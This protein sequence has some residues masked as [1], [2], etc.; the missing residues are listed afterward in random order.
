MSNTRKQ[1]TIYTNGAAEP[2]PGPGGYVVRKSWSTAGSSC[3]D[4][5][6]RSM[7]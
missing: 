3:E 5:A 1:V 6:P 4:A 2:N 7:A